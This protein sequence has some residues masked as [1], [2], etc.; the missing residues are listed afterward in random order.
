MSPSERP[1][2]PVSLFFSYSRKDKALRDQLETHLSLLQTQGVISGWHDRRIVA[3]TEWD[4]AISK[5]L[6]EADI[7]LLLVSADYLALRFL[8]DGEDK[9]AMEGPEGGTARVIPVILRSVD[10]HT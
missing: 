9:G 7:I 6:E 5:N 3:G 2:T 10:W 1:A 8:R 4:G